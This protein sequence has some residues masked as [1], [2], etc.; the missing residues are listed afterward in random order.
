MTA[1]VATVIGG[2]PVLLGDL[3]ITALGSTEAHIS[4]PSMP[5]ALFERYLPPEMYYRSVRGLSRKVSVLCPGLA[6]GWA[7]S[8]FG[9]RIVFR[10]IRRRLLLQEGLS[11]RW[12]E[13]TIREEVGDGL[14][15]ALDVTLLGW[16]DDVDHQRVM[17]F[18]YSITN[19]EGL[20]VQPTFSTTQGNVTLQSGPHS[21][22][23]MDTGQ[24]SSTFVRGI[25]SGGYAPEMLQSLMIGEERS[26]GH[27]EVLRDVYKAI[28][29]PYLNSMMSDNLSMA[30]TGGGFEAIYF[31][32]QSAAFRYLE[33]IS[34]LFGLQR[35]ERFVPYRSIV[36]S[37]HVAYLALGV[38][39]HRPDA[40]LEERNQRFF[41]RSILHPRPLLVPGHTMQSPLF[42][43]TPWHGLVTDM[44]ELRHLPRQMRMVEINI[45]PRDSEHRALEPMGGG[46]YRI[47]RAQTHELLKL[48]GRSS[49][50]SHTPG[51]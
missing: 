46:V 51:S 9:A 18:E 47:H 27:E 21:F 42:G 3:M 40:T 38:H 49:I 44:Q 19:A 37:S 7:G 41:A 11:L 30:A 4:I 34:L 39:D 16:I 43:Q 1:V 22:R 48:M 8:E 32:T 26:M 45:Q 33:P 2:V 17:P 5:R 6:M 12:L 13:A 25:G 29:M 35:G 28:A 14:G 10:S 23:N 31:D 50:T 24:P 15:S 36:Q 20:I